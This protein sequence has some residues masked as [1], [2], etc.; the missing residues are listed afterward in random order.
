MIDKEKMIK[1]VK[2]EMQI[3]QGKLDELKVQAKLGQAELRNAVQPE[4]DRIESEMG[5]LGKRLKEMQ[6]ASGKAFEE[7]RSGMGTALDAI[8]SSV[9]K[10]SSHFRK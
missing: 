3:W 5:K 1:S 4:I 2:E 6:E 8:K 10:A 7:I 9:E